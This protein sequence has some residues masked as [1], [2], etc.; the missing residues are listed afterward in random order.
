MKDAAIHWFSRHG[1]WGNADLW[2]HPDGTLVSTDTHFGGDRQDNIAP[3]EVEQLLNAAFAARFWESDPLS[4]R[5]VPDETQWTLNAT[6]KGEQRQGTLFL[7]LW[8]RE[9][10]ALTAKLERLRKTR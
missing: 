7:R 9:F 3:T 5:P 1:L 6:R 10:P 2:L 4:H 8:E